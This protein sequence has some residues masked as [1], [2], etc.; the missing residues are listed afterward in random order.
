MDRTD[1]GIF[2]RLMGDA[3]R[4]DETL[5]REVGLTG[6]AVRLRRKR[7]EADGVLTEYG[8][9]PPAQ[10]LGRHAATWRYVGKDWSEVSL[11]QLSEVEDLAYVMSF[12]PKVHVVVRFTT[13]PS[14]RA[15]P[16]LARILGRPLAQRAEEMPPRA[17]LRTEALSLV[18]W[19]VLEAVVR[20]PRAPY[21]V[22]ARSAG[23]SPRTLRIHAS[24][25]EALN[26][27]ECIMIVN[28][29]REAGLATYGIWLKVDE[30]FDRKAVELPRLWD[31]PHWTQTPRGVYL[32][33]SAENYFEARELELRLRSLPG[34][35]GAD[36]LIPAGG[37]FAR[38][39][40]LEWIRAERGRR[41]RP[42]VPREAT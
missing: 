29:V 21:S 27:L 41:F 34:V 38:E 6:K 35:V 2:S 24:R 37:W 17:S 8:V 7:M 12:R 4:S 20:A 14:P 13:D 22:Q 10:I 23:L 11:A 9:H 25:L 18:D 15:D 16:R 26:A 28:L 40:L 19:R 36:P 1:L 33:G 3:F 31:R 30:S 42:A 32:L 39:R 5:A